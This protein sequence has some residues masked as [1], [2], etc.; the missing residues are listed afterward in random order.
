MLDLPFDSGRGATEG[1]RASYRTR[2]KALASPEVIFDLHRARRYIS[3][4]AS[5][6]ISYRHE[7]QDHSQ[8]VR[9]LAERLHASGV[10]VVF[11]QFLL[12]EALGGPDEG[13][14]GWLYRQAVNAEKILVVASPG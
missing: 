8:R 9:G 5:V 4:M 2:R 3:I 11:D 6:F 12:D 14:S 1:D 13:W 10:E 7:N